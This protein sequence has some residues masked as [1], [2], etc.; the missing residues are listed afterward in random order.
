M[1][2]LMHSRLEF[3][4]PSPYTL[5]LPRGLKHDRE[6]PLVMCLHGMGGHHD[7]MR[8]WMGPLLSHPWIFCF[9]RGPLP[10]EQRLPD[11]RRIGYAWYV[12]D[13]D[14][15][16][17]RESMQLSI[18]HLHNIQDLVRKQYPVG[19]TAIIGF[20]QGGYLAPVVAGN[21]PGRF[22]AAASICGRIK[23]EFLPSGGGAR[24][25]QFS[26]GRDGSIAP[27]LASAGA[28][29]AREKGY[30]V[31]EHLDPEAGHEVTPLILEQLR[32]WLQEVL[33]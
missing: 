17:L 14:Q 25:A 3:K 12:F 18:E 28:H 20:S 27:E 19:R 31:N 2:E 23:H 4:M 29:G 6:W 11:K 8:R 26:G 5:A 15:E 33:E 7:L 32:A 10:F 24:L 1:S 16:A 13:G 22:C 9:P 21:A 30:T